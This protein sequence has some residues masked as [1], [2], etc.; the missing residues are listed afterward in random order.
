[1]HLSVYKALV[2]QEFYGNNL[3]E[4]VLQTA[5]QVG[6]ML[7][8]HLSKAHDSI[9]VPDESSGERERVFRVLYGMDKQRA[10]L[11]GG[12][13]DLYHFDSDLELW[14]SVDTK[15]NEVNSPS[16]KLLAAFD[17]MMM[18]WEEIYLKLYS[19]RAIAAGAS[20]A[21]SQVA[22]LKDLLAKW[23]EHHPGVL[24]TAMSHPPVG[25][26]DVDDLVSIQF[27]LRYCYHVT[28]V[29]VLRCE[30][31]EDERAQMQMRHH[32]R[33]SLQLIVEMSN[34]G[35]GTQPTPSRV[36]KARLATLSRVLGSYP[37]IAFMDLV[38]F[39]LD[40]FIPSRPQPTNDL[41]RG[42]SPDAEADI[43]LLHAVPRLVQGLQHADRPSTYL[44]RL[45]LGLGWAA[46]VL[47]ETRKAWLM[48]TESRELS[49]IVASSPGV[50][51][52]AISTDGSTSAVTSGIL[53]SGWEN[54][55]STLRQTQQQHEQG[56]NPTSA[57]DRMDMDMGMT[58]S[59]QAQ[60]PANSGFTPVS[61]D[62]GSGGFGGMYD[63]VGGWSA[64]PSLDGMGEG[65]GGHVPRTS[66]GG[67]GFHGLDLWQDFFM[68]EKPDSA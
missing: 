42:E 26:H 60:M 58:S 56:T 8:L 23:H 66:T 17:D 19:T 46:R 27:E 16:R 63:S 21:S 51:S 40:A 52:N 5:C 11:T 53:S 6:R 10:F 18:I 61:S 68:Q 33:T 50:G 54:L 32:A 45:G 41:A 44:N 13:C 34:I 3:F 47:D 55:P 65:G 15:P 28:Q 30:R 62:L 57:S 24:E 9:H 4:K 37:M 25:G 59:T 7:G 67:C 36:A 14:Q 39:R 22:G 31:S 2:A 12:P 43:K 1:M 35:D 49:V 48:G 64:V 38:A 29:L 20:Y